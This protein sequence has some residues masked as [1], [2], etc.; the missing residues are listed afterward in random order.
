MSMSVST[1]AEVLR[2]ATRDSIEKKWMIYLGQAALMCL[3]GFFALIYPIFSTAA[4]SWV[5]GWLLIINGI[6]QGIS[7]ISARHL[8]HF[9]IQVIS[10][11]LSLIVGFFI[12][13]QLAEGHMLLPI[14]LVMFLLLE[15][16]S[17]TIFALT[18]RPMKN[19]Y[20]V[21]GSGALG[22]LLSFILWTTM[23]GTSDWLLGLFIGV[24][25]F[26]E[27]AAIGYLV[28]KLKNKI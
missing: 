24:L 3:T 2:A 6:V 20:M 1:A 18:I 8:P 19:W 28:L 25:L 7:L 14:M 10:V 27:G 11:V 12:L 15:G 17:K 22:I 16:V 13:N 4:I 23:P 9:W 26:S 5:L 21:L